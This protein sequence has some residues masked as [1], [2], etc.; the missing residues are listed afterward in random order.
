M[1]AHTFE[2]EALSYDAATS[3]SEN[4]KQ[5]LATEQHPVLL[6]VED[7]PD[8][9]TYIRNALSDHYHIREAANGKEGLAKAQQE[10]PD[11]IISDIMMPE[12]DGFKFCGLI[13][14]NELTSHIPVI[15]LTAKA[16]RDSKL[17]GLET[18]AD[19]YLS[20]PF[21]TEE[22]RL[23]IR[24][25]IEHRRKMREHFRKEI[26]L[27]PNGIAITSLDE[28]FLGKALDIIEKHMDDE[29]FSIVDFSAE[30]G[31]SHIQFYRKLKAL[32]GQTPN[33]F[34]RTIR[35]KRAAE[36]LRNNSDHIAQVAYSVG[37]GSESYFIRCFK[38]QYGMTPGQY[39]ERKS[40][41]HG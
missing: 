21:D 39:S 29:L 4:K 14:S 25:R 22:L 16:D 33:Q 9:R 32:T 2:V 35:L 36:L 31:Y 1:H 38:E 40:S 41:L 11:L 30:A 28:K 6:M 12:M 26:T 5:L 8:M 37:F 13:K 17:E 19:D 3:Q 10:I 24:N 7:N 27:E 34:L 23:I 15:L 20:K 18:G